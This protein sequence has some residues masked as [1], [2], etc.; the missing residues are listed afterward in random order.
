MKLKKHLKI[1]E[2]SLLFALCASLCAGLWAGA[3]QRQL[4]GELVRLHVIAQSDSEEDQQLK[5]RVRDGVLAALEPRLKNAGSTEQAAAIIEDALPLLCQVADNVSENAG[6]SY[7]SQ[8]SLGVENYPTR[9]YD[10]FALPAGDYLSLKITLGDGGGQNWW[11]VVFP[12]LC[13]TA[14]SGTE[15]I[16]ALS[17][18]SQ[19]IISL[20][21][22]E[23]RL[24]FHVIEIFEKVRSYLA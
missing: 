24:E 15:A 19:N 2:M 11:C 3:K 16:E 22:E 17:D 14:A 1:W 7:R 12:P 6:M 4:S 21:G 18:D 20:D 8:A 10:D 13:L 5:L 9:E 23:Y